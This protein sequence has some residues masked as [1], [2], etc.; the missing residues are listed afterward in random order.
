M[1]KY[2]LSLQLGTIMYVLGTKKNCK[3][4]SDK[5]QI[6]GLTYIRFIIFTTTCG[7]FQFSVAP[8]PPSPRYSYAVSVLW[9]NGATA[10]AYGSK[11]I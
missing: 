3:L 8:F 2:E 1:N 6:T 7:S 9:F 10:G 11:H 5:F 4:H